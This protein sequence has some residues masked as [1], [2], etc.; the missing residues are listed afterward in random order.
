MA[1]DFQNDFRFP[2]G[3]AFPTIKLLASKISI[4]LTVILLHGCTAYRTTS[5]R[6]SAEQELL[7]ATAADRAAEALAAQVPSGLTAWIDTEAL[8]RRE[9]PYAIGAIQDA[10]LRRGVKLVGDRASAD[11]VVLPRAGMLST[12]ERSTFVG[13][14]PLPLPLAPGV[15][16]PALSVYSQNKSD[17]AAKFAASVYDAKS[18]K[19]LISTEPSFGFSHQ[20]NGTVL[21]AF[22]WRK[23]DAGVSF[24]DSPPHLVSSQDRH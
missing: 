3:C 23:N 7:I 12:E 24:K 14:P 2:V 1:D 17:G 18:G 16:L 10:L 20:E 8:S 21:F 6:E 9:H 5:P 22:T 13:V 11:A 15:V 19:L 4:L